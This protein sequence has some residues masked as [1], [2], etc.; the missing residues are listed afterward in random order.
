MNCIKKLS[1]FLVLI[2]L[3]S[4]SFIACSADQSIEPVDNQADEL[5]SEETKD[6]Q[7]NEK[8][9]QENEVILEASE[10]VETIEIE[11]SHEN[12]SPES[13]VSSD[14]ADEAYEA[15]EDL[16]NEET[17]SETISDEENSKQTDEVNEENI[18]ESK[19]SKE[20]NQEALNQL[21]IKGSVENPL[22]LSLDELK[23]MEN[24]IYSEV[25]YS[26]NSFGT[27]E[28]TDFKGI[29][30]WPLLEEKAHIL[31]GAKTVKIVAIDG[32]HVSFTIDEVKRD[33]YIDETNQ[34][35]QLPIIIAWEENGEAYDP[36]EGPPYKLVIGQKAPGDVNKPQWV[37][38]I[39]V[40]I[41]E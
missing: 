11:S 23:A 41:V 13:V 27:T 26:L 19:D 5:A 33:D 22:A 1:I 40:I 21:K 35:L 39:D 18:P 12:N 16:K 31:E 24:L 17:S 15:G 36:K 10:S 6:D 14:E 38:D 29:K 20:N 34:N 9:E 30:L 25:F 37:R 32:Y 7:M 4:I 3:F 28:Y 8:V 2:V